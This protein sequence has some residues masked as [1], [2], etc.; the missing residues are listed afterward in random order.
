MVDSHADFAIPPECQFVADVIAVDGSSPD[1]VDQVCAGMTSAATWPDYGID[2]VTFRSTVRA[3][4]PTSPAGVL[5]LFY[6]SYAARH[7]KP[8]WGDKTPGTVKRMAAIARV[9]PE[10]R[11][12]HLIRDGLDVAAS[13]RD[14]WFGPS[15]SYAQC[16][17]HWAATI[18]RAREQRSDGLHYLELR[19]EALVTEPADALRRVCDFLEC[20][21]DPAMLSYPARAEE[22]LAEFVDLPLGGA[23]RAMRLGIHLTTRES[24]LRER[25]GRWRDVMT[26]AEV[27]AC[28]AAGGD[29]L[30]EFRAE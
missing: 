15:E 13:L 7:G 19:Y 20:E 18:A 29:T 14:L 25:I 11:F 28:V 16:V 5:R 4:A 12:I 9:L 6:R 17:S 8:H 30:R 27:A 3:A 1:W 23:S 10:A 2:A 21:Y 24:P 26:P 22:R